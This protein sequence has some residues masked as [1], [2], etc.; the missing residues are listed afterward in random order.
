[1]SL[2]RA[3]HAGN[4]ISSARAADSDVLGGIALSADGW[5]YVSSIGN[6]EWYNVTKRDDSDKFTKVATP[7]DAS[8]AYTISELGRIYVA[9]ASG[10][11]RN[12][13]MLARNSDGVPFDDLAVSLDGSYLVAINKVGTLTMIDL[14]TN[15]KYDRTIPVDAT[16]VAVSEDGEKILVG[17]KG[18]RLMVS[19]D[20][21]SSWDEVGEA[22]SISDVCMKPDGTR[23]V[24]A[25]SLGAVWAS[26]DFG[27]SWQ[28]IS[29][30]ELAWTHLACGTHMIAATV[31]RYKNKPSAFI[32]YFVKPTNY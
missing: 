20:S 16:S 5:V 15:Q 8:K 22:R 28:A 32:T 24:A 9:L 18:S 29:P 7:G 26:E 14:R 17:F 23:M 12:W 11:Y 30:A 1:M 19:T 10:G 25:E 27:A 4:F 31:D 3:A 13:Q 6:R 21:G 2:T